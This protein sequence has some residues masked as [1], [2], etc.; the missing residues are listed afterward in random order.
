MKTDVTDIWKA[1]GVVFW[2]VAFSVTQNALYGE[3]LNVLIISIN[4]GLVGIL[5]YSVFPYFGFRFPRTENQVVA[6]FL[7]ML[8]C[9]FVL[10]LGL[11][12]KFLME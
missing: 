9:V 2:G 11:A 12:R 4:I 10:L 5:T 6:F 8:A 3:R 1:S 7:P